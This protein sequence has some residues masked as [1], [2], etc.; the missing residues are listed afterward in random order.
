MS[1]I[2]CHF[3]LNSP[4]ASAMLFPS[5]RKERGEVRLRAWGEFCLKYDNKLF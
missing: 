4:L 3:C 2:I 5:L 1:Y